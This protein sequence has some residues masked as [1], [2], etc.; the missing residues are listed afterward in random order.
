VERERGLEDEKGHEPAPS[1]QSEH[2]GEDGQRYEQCAGEQLFT[3]KKGTSM[4]GEA[5]P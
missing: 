3:H 4:F 1:A 2:G 5:N